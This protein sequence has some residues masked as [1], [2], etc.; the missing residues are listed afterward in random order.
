MESGNMH[1][2]EPPSQSLFNDGMGTLVRSCP[3]ED[4]IHC[5]AHELASDTMENAGLLFLCMRKRLQDKDAM[6]EVSAWR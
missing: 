2:G 4:E 5:G 1:V 6:Y 3:D